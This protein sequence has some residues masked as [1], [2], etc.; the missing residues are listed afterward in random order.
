MW[1]SPKRHSLHHFSWKIRAGSW[2]GLGYV[3]S[4]KGM[5]LDPRRY[6]LG[7]AAGLPA[8]SLFSG[9]D[10]SVCVSKVGGLFHTK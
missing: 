2:G 9:R 3:E 4:G 10:Q 1:L 5:Q 8:S 7:V 6:P